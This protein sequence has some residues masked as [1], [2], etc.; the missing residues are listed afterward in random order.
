MQDKAAR[1]RLRLETPM[2][3]GSPNVSLKS[4]FQHLPPPSPGNPLKTIA[5]VVEQ[6]SV[7]IKSEEVFNC[8]SI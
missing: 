1:Q 6:T 7:T 8:G 2:Y 3:D 4:N 5:L